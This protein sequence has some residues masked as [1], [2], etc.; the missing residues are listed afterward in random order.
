[1]PTAS[2]PNSLTRSALHYAVVFTKIVVV[3]IMSFVSYRPWRRHINSHTLKACMRKLLIILNVMLKH[4][5]PWRQGME[6]PGAGAWE[7]LGLT[8]FGRSSA[9]GLRRC[10]MGESADTRVALAVTIVGDGKVL[11]LQRPSR[12]VVRPHR[13]GLAS[14]ILSLP[15]YLSILS[16]KRRLFSMFGKTSCPS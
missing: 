4:R 9:N 2:V 10:F 12:S 3:S 13:F 16:Q 15:F 14:N 1:M 8:V 5:T 7:S 6:G 11:S